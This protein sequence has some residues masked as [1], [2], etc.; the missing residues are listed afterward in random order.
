MEAP[1]RVRYWFVLRPFV[2]VVMRR[3]VAA[4]RREA[5]REPER[6]RDGLGRQSALATREA[7]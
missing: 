2:G 6:E 1:R 3:A 7:R 5:E 4:I